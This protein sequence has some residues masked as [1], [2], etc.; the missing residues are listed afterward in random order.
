[1]QQ[2]R[3]RIPIGFIA[4]VVCLFLSR[5]WTVLDVFASTPSNSSDNDIDISPNHRSLRRASYFDPKT[6]I[7]RPPMRVASPANNFVHDVTVEPLHICGRPVPIDHNIDMLIMHKYHTSCPLRNK[8]PEDTTIVYLGSHTN[9][10]G[11]GGPGGKEGA[12]TGNNL[13]ELLHALQYA[14]DNDAVLVI[15]LWTWPISLITM[16]WIEN[17]NND[18]TAWRS[19]VEQALCI[20]IVDDDSD[21]DQY[22]AV[23]RKENTKEL[24][25][26]VH[27]AN[28]DDASL[29]EYIEYQSY[30]IRTLF[31]S[32]NK[33][34]G[35]R[36]SKHVNVTLPASNMC[37]VLSGIHELNSID[38]YSVIHSRSGVS[39]N[40]LQVSK[41]SGTDRKAAVSMEPDYIKS[42]LAPLG[43]LNRPILFICDGKHP[44]ILERLMADSDIGPWIQIP[45]DS[46]WVGG[47][48][49]AGIMATVFIG[50]PGSTFSGFIAKSR[51][52]LGFTD[53]YLFRKRDAGGVW[54]NA[55]DNSCI[56]N[57]NIMNMHS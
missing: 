18:W 8:P 22:R 17:Q 35:T 28:N 40:L 13:I 56:F 7:Q 10:Y 2:H 33:G 44:E 16:M 27:D 14:R 47:D 51:Y 41:R 6:V 9:A 1:M 32:Y 12:G 21:F 5:P 52:A 20:K 50:N 38:T 34:I 19:F 24:F 11:D 36:A 30:I 15:K 37:S 31:R 29:E 55:C 39:H 54:G 23:I 25:R 46:S 48:I 3:H 57:K 26:L 53:T 42:I 45:S 49:T 43:M 4:I